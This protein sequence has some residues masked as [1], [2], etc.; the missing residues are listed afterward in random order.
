MPAMSA[1]FLA[2]D[3]GGRTEAVAVAYVLVMSAVLSDGVSLRLGGCG[4]G[5]RGEREQGDAG[6]AELLEHAVEGGLVDH[7]TA[8]DRGAVGP[9]GDG[10][11]V[12]PGRPEGCQMP[13]DP[14]LVLRSRG[15]NRLVC[16]HERTVRTDLVS[17][18]HHMW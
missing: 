11:A 7:G 18:H 8:E 5:K 14:D 9:G 4:R 6:V 10:Q 17:R 16:A 15:G 13:G 1:A 12:D 3:I 2:G